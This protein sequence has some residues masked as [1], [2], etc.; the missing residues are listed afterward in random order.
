MCL[1]MSVLLQ[2]AEPNLAAAAAAVWNLDQL[3]LTSLYLALLT[4]FPVHVCVAAGS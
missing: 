4:H 3:Q 2:A 1:S